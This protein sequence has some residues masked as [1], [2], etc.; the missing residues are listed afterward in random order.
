M[1]NEYFW[2]QMTSVVVITGVLC[3][4]LSFT[5]LQCRRKKDC[6]DSSVDFFWVIVAAATLKVERV[7]GTRVQKRSFMNVLITRVK[8]MVL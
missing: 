6:E 3:E 5:S 8:N 1:K 4:L 7:M 2:E